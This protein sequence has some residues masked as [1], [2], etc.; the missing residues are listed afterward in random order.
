MQFG[1]S[2]VWSIFVA[3]IKKNFS[4]TTQ[5]TQT[6]QIHQHIHNAALGRIHWWKEEE[7]EQEEDDAI[8]VNERYDVVQH[9]QLWID[10]GLNGF[11]GLVPKHV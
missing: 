7:E 1:R 4:N 2:Y 10:N 3:L 9:A 6:T 8:T 11:L 5:T